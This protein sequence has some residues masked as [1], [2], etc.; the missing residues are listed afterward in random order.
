MPGIKV[1]TKKLCQSSASADQNFESLLAMLETIQ[2]HLIS[3]VAR[4]LQDFA[5]FLEVAELILQNRTAEKRENF[6]MCVTH[7]PGR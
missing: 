6:C 7:G 1:S 5:V 2:L 4:S 3:C